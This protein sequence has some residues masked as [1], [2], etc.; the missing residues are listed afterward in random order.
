MHAEVRTP[1]VLAL[2]PCASIKFDSDNSGVSEVASQM[3]PI[4][5]NPQ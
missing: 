3:K 1:E 5:N 4:I 2:K